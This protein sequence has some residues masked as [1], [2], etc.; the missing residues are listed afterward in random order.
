MASIYAKVDE[1]NYTYLCADPK[2]ADVISVPVKPGNGVVERG[3][4]MFREAN[5]QYS[6]AATADVV[7]TKD[8]VVINETVDTTGEVAE[9][10]AVYRAGRLIDEKVKLAAGAELSAANKIV[11]RAQGIKL[12]PA[13]NV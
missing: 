8:L 6:P 12:D 2:D 9:V 1:F 4:V 13:I 10:A 11:L 5:G 3:T 7:A